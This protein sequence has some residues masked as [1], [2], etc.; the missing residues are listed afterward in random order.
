MDIK[1]FSI[2]TC[3]FKT[4]VLVF[5]FVCWGNDCFSPF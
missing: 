4:I 5:F 2:I 3:F 1:E